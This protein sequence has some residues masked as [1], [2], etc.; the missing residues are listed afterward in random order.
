ME[1]ETG[2]GIVKVIVGSDGKWLRVGRSGGMGVCFGVSDTLARYLANLQ[3]NL[4]TRITSTLSQCQQA[5]QCQPNLHNAGQIACQSNLRSQ[6]QLRTMQ[7]RLRASL[8][9]CQFAA[10]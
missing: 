6:P 3:Y 5:L 2:K 10:V 4:H 9:N 8:S 7:A 1:W